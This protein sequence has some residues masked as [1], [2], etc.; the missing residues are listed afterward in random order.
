MKRYIIID[1]YSDYKKLSDEKGLKELLVEEL[2]R[3]TFESDE[4]NVT[5][6]NFKVMKK[7]ALDD[8]NFDYLKDQLESYGWFVM[9]LCEL[10]KNLNDYQAFKHGVGAPSYPQDCIAKTIDLVDKDLGVR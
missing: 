8:Y 1:S 9:D 4:E 5:K 10:Q 3:D 7:L 2:E 6:Q